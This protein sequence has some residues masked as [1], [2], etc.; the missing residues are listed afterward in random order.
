MYVVIWVWRTILFYREKKGDCIHIEGGRSI[1]RLSRKRK[2]LD[3][4]NCPDRSNYLG[5]VIVWIEAN[6]WIGATILY[7]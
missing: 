2:Y 1:G 6:I 4:G 3:R 5:R 7:G